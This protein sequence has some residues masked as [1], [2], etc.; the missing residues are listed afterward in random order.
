MLKI[1][2]LDNR[3][4]IVE[5]AQSLCPP[6]LTTPLASHL[7]FP[8]TMRLVGRTASGDALSRHRHLEV[9][10]SEVPAAPAYVR[11]IDTVPRVRGASAP[12]TE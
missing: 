5:Q 4:H 3:F 12:P 11:V 6:A 2:R 9:D 8:K 10:K 1:S 7:G